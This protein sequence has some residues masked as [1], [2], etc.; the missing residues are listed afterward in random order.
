MLFVS[1][2]FGKELGNGDG[3]QP[4]RIQPD[5]PGHDQPVEIGAHRQTDGGPAGVGHAGKV[6]ETGKSHQQP[7]AHVG[8]LGAHSR[9]QR[10]QLTATQ[11]KI[12]RGP[13]LSGTGCADSQHRNQIDENRKDYANIS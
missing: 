3:L 11:I 9:H 12:I 13:V 1:K 7:T 6:R 4:L 5:A 8:C 10:P 2:A